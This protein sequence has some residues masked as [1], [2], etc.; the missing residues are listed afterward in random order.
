MRKPF[1]LATL[2]RT[3]SGVLGKQTPAIPGVTAPSPRTPGAK[4]QFRVLA[5]EDDIPFFQFLALALH[6]EDVLYRVLDGVQAMEK[7][8]AISPDLIIADVM[9]PRMSGIEMLRALQKDILGRTIPIIF[10]TAISL[11]SEHGE[12]MKKDFPNLKFVLQKP[13][14]V[15]VLRDA[16]DSIFRRAS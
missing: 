4:K 3:V 15:K 1:D 5:V 12:L 9:M 2:R 10:L 16:V 7:F 14:D 13:C 11:K 8:K 6:K